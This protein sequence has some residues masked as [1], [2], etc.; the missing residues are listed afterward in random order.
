MK[1]T[2]IEAKKFNYDDLDKKLDSLFDKKDD[3]YQTEYLVSVKVNSSFVKQF[4][5]LVK[6]MKSNSDPGHSFSIWVDPPYSMKI[7][8]GVVFNT[9]MDGDGS[10]RI[11][12]IDVEKL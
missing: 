7:P 3:P 2:I 5:D 8:N 6:A 4:V 9:G 11:L 10:D 1:Y 12:D